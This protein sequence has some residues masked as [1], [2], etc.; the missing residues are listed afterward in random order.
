MPIHHRAPS[1]YADGARNGNPH[2][3]GLYQLPLVLMASLTPDLHLMSKI[4][5][6]E[7]NHEEMAMIAEFLSSRGFTPVYSLEPSRWDT[8]SFGEHEE[9]G[10]WKSVRGDREWRCQEPIPASLILDHF[11]LGGKIR[12]CHFPANPEAGVSLAADGTSQHEAITS[13]ALEDCFSDPNAVFNNG[14]S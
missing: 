9:G 6:A 14:A 3:F 1:I 10:G 11:E 13:E 7:G 12:L 4:R 8:D 5:I 2:D